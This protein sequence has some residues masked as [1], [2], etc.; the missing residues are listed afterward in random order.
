MN[1][2]FENSMEK[3]SPEMD[4]INAAVREAGVFVVL[5]YSEKDHGSL[6][7][8]QVHHDKP[9]A[10]KQSTADSNAKSLLSIQPAPS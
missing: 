8:A 3:D 4:Q 10:V 1:E 6:Y 9:S 7:I 5:G 2:Y